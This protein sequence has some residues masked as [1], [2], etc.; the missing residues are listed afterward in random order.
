MKDKVIKMYIDN[1][2]K[3]D[4]I[5]Y[6]KKNNITAESKDIDYV[7]NYVKKLDN[8][9]DIKSHINMMKQHVSKNGALILDMLYNKYMRYL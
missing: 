5:T 2:K 8:F 9:N 4:I 7:Y 1:L 3:E 6:V